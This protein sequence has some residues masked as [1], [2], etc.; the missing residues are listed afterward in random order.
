MNLQQLLTDLGI[1]GIVVAGLSWTA[2]HISQYFIDRRFAAYKSELQQS[3]QQYKLE[4]EHDLEKHRS[5]LQFEYLKHSRIHERRL[6]VVAELYELLFH[7]DKAMRTTTAQLR[8][9]TGEDWETLRQREMKDAI[10]AYKSFVDYFSMHRLFLSQESCDLLEKL[11]DEYLETYRLGTFGDRYS[12]VP[13]DHL[14]DLSQKA[15]DKIQT[16]VPTLK[17]KLE[18][19]FRQEIGIVEEAQNES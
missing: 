15:S 3:A 13:S 16:Q 14:R 9:S 17:S 12:E 19:E 1:F 4:L 10:E 18:Q 11:K 8:R 6:E 5:R 7:L 2:R